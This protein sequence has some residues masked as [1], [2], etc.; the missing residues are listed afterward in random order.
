MKEPS[1]ELV[2]SKNSL[3]QSNNQRT[4]LGA[5]IQT[6]H[7]SNI[8]KTF[9]GK[10]LKDYNSDDMAKLVELM[11]RW[12]ILLGVTSEPTSEELTII[13]QFAYE[14][15]PHLTWDDFYWAMTG[16]IMGKYDLGFIMQK[17]LNT[18][19]VTK[20]LNAYLAEK[21]E[22]VNE[23]ARA[24]EKYEMERQSKSVEMTPEQRA[25]NF[26]EHLV[27]MY[28]AYKD[29]GD[30][31][32]MDLGG[33]VYDWMRRAKVLEPTQADI[34]EALSYANDRY[35]AERQE[36]NMRKLFVEAIDKKSEEIQRKKLARVF[37]IAKV[38]DAHEWMDLA[39]MVKP[40]HFSEKNLVGIV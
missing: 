35:I 20:A 10:R 7:Q 25:N 13:C 24:K 6:P 5:W 11:A 37:L 22:I 29:G 30:V 9:E 38:F 4:L 1:K 16:A 34:T 36:E 18:F 33:L 8:A 31:R 19:Y 23:I 21:A 12:R 17:N 40:E 26:R 28:R 15:Y 14:N 32:I 3:A 2:Q 27:T 39:K